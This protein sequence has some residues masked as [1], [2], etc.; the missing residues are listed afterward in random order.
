AQ[1]QTW[2]EHEHGGRITHARHSH[3]TRHHP[4]RSCTPAGRMRIMRTQCRVSNIWAEAW[5]G[6]V[7][8]T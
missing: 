2:E 7:Q 1:E 5:A 3:I 8:L 4:A 6:R